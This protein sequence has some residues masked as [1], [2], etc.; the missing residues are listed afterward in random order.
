MARAHA[1]SACVQSDSIKGLAQSIAKPAYLRLLIAE[2]ALRRAVPILIIAFLIT[3]CLGAFVQVLDHHRQKRASLKR[4][5]AALADVLAERIDRIASSRQNHSATF[6]RLQLLLPGLIPSW[7]VAPGR[8]V[9]VIGA[10]Q[11]VLARVPI[12]AG[13]GDTSRIL[14]IISAALPLTA[15]GQQVGAADITLPNGSSALAVQQ[16][17]KSL[18]GQVIIIQERGESLWRSDAALSVTLSA[19]TGFVV[20]ILGFAFHWQS[21]R[22]REGDLINDAVRGRI[23]TALNRGR[24]GLWDWDLSRG[25]IFWSQSMFTMLGLDSRSD[26]LTFGELNAL[27]KSDDIDLFAIADQLVSSK[28][29]HIDQTF[30]MQHTDGHWIWL[31]VRCELSQGAAD[32]GL[33]LIG[34]AVDITEQKSLAEK[35]VEAD[36]RLR[37]AIETIPEAFVLWDAGD[38]LVLC[39]SHFQRLHKL[40]DSAVT[41]GTSY[42]TVIE[43]GSMPEVRTRLHETG[44]HAP[45]AR[46][47][48]AQLE[49]GSWLHISER[50][51]KDGGYVSVGTDITRIKAHEQ[52]L[53]DNDLRLRATVFDLKR[54]QAELEKQAVELADLAEKY[55]SEKN[56]AEEANQTKS[57]FLANMSHE[58]RT[59]LNAIIGFSEIMGSGMFGT[60][61]SEKYH[62]YC[63]DIL[64]SGHYLLEVINDI[65]DMSKIEA[66]RMKLDMESLDLSKTL[67]ESLR[68]VSGRADDKHLVLDADIEG[69]IP[70]V[71]DRRAIKQIIVNLLSNAV[72]FTPEGGKV[73]VRSR[74]FSDSIILTIADTGIGIAPQSLARLGRPFEQV[75]SQLT[76]TYHGSGLGLAIARS[77]ANLHGGSMRLRSKIGAGTVVCVSL[78]R[79]G[80]KSKAKMSAAA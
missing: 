49:D 7:G 46:T 9:I 17:V 28:I 68:V 1:A 10:D 71:A 80:G 55:S 48:E 60:L 30:R 34:I 12:D 36:L 50:R 32:S 13:L 14:D 52:K 63:H 43:V 54:S 58:L 53:V 75:E 18:P 26:L 45:G 59:P 61:G 22:A 41:P 5:L 23:D 39:N 72:K 73:L 11:R 51:T 79:E 65:L 44:V 31:R 42:E 25:R 77:L 62:E 67:A 33:H 4:D 37:D 78:P 21:S 76:K 64:T 3:I 19:T 47:F 24:C 56:R 15:P 2:P 8:H 16:I 38:R 74:V 66:G 20:L 70:V 57:K 35:T 69:T 27:V 6:D 29:D 40:P